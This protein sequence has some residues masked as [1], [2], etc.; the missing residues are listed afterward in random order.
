[1]K[2]QSTSLRLNEWS[3]VVQSALWWQRMTPLFLTL[4]PADM[5]H[6]PASGCSSSPRSRSGF[7]ANRCE[8]VAVVQVVVVVQ[9][10]FAE[11]RRDGGRLLVTWRQDRHERRHL[12]P[13]EDD[14]LSAR[15]AESARSCDSPSIRGME[16][17]EDGTDES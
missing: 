8:P 13:E 11:E 6:L 3:R 1:M 16:S 15:E 2:E 10:R 14:S 4:N 17:S 7:T 12:F 5:H 9:L